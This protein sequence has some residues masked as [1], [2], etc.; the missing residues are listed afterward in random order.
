MGMNEDFQRGNTAFDRQDYNEALKLYLSAAGQGHVGAMV[1]VGAICWNV[2]E[3][4]A[5]VGWWNKAAAQ[6]NADAMSC[7]CMAYYEGKGVP[8]NEAEAVRWQ[9]KAEAAKRSAAAPASRQ[10]AYTVSQAPSSSSSSY[11]SS[12]SSSDYDDSESGLKKFGFFGWYSD[13]LFIFAMVVTI[14]CMIA[15][16]VV[17]YFKIGIDFGAYSLLEIGLAY[18][19]AI[20]AAAFVIILLIIKAIKDSFSLTA[21]GAV[22]FICMLLV[23]GG[24][25]YLYFNPSSIENLLSTVSSKIVTATVTVT[26]DALNLRASSTGTS[27]VIKTLK[28]GDRLTVTGNAHD[29]W[30]PVRHDGVEGWVSEQYVEK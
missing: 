18:S 19:I 11:R 24:S 28:K 3:Y 30:L 23:I 14:L 5:A 6:G 1:K 2:G 9:N 17:G 29:G 12:S 13:G 7:L 22:P 10:G 27:E 26:A 25:L 20:F 8:K 15:G 21:E 16:A 4:G